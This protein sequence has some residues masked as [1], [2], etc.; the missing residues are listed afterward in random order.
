MLAHMELPE[1]AFICVC[2]V[3]MIASGFG[4]WVTSDPRGIWP[5]F[6]FSECNA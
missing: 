5:L 4:A 2:D 3:L 1:I 6:T